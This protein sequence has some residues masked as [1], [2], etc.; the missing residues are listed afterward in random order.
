MDK[1]GSSKQVNAEEDGFLIM[2]Q[3]WALLPPD[4]ENSISIEQNGKRILTFFMLWIDENNISPSLL[5]TCKNLASNPPDWPG[6]RLEFTETPS[7]GFLI[8]IVKGWEP[9]NSKQ[10]QSLF[11]KVLWEI[12]RLERS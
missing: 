6:V 5:A 10:E 8:R 2:D 7:P 1:A 9:A 12:N 3:H 4:P 11:Q